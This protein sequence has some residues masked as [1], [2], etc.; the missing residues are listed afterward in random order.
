MTDRNPDPGGLTRVGLRPTRGVED[1]RPDDAWV[2]PRGTN[3]LDQPALGGYMVPIKDPETGR[4]GSVSYIE[5]VRNGYLPPGLTRREIILS[6]A[7]YNR[8]YYNDYWGISG[9]GG[10]GGRG[11]GGAAG[12]TYVKPDERLVR[13]AVRGDLVAL[14]GK[15]DPAKIDELVST[16]MSEAKRAFDVRETEQVDPM[17]TVKAK[18]R[19]TAE[20]KAI[21]QL[22]PDSA[23]EFDWVSSRIGA[24]K[25]AGVTD[26]MAEELGISQATVGASVQDAVTAGNIATFSQSGKLLD[27]LKERI[28][29]STYSALRLI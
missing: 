1:D 3:P 18:I 13:E 2:D 8:A 15:A 4:R 14:V 22:R 20:Y 27:E 25:R 12:P 9:G 5:L 17:E 10:G 19:E 23:D 7:D 29:V 6:Y 11:G 28:N 24:L 21:H 16:Y 26:A